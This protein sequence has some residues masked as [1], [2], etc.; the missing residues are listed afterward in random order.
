MRDTVG[1]LG[2]L[3]EETIEPAARDALLHAFRDWKQTSP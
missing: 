1:A 3:S 2:R